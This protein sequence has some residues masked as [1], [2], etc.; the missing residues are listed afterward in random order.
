MTIVSYRN[1]FSVLYVYALLLSLLVKEI[2]FKNEREKIGFYF[3]GLGEIL[4]LLPTYPFEGSKFHVVLFQNVF[5]GLV[6]F[7][8][9]K[10]GFGERR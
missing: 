7:L 3:I 10:N 9:L 8:V 6:Q 1:R 5:C 4:S 2:G